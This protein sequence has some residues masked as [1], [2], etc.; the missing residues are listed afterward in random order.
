[1][2]SQQKFDPPRPPNDQEREPV[3]APVR[4]L[5]DLD[6]GAHHDEVGAFVSYIIY[7]DDGAIVYVDRND[8]LNYQIS[9]RDY[10]QWPADMSRIEAAAASLDAQPLDHLGNAQKKQ[11]LTLCGQGMAVILAK[12][13]LRDAI[14]ILKQAQAYFEARTSEVFRQRYLFFILLAVL[15][16]CGCSFA[17][18]QYHDQL[19]E[20]Y[21][22]NAGIIVASAFLASLGVLVSV[23]LRLEAIR[24]SSV[25]PIR[26]HLLESS[27][28]VL[29][30]VIAGFVTALAIK[31]GVILEGVIADTSLDLTLV[32]A[33]IVSGLSERALPNLAKRLQEVGVD[34]ISDTQ[35]EVSDNDNQQVDRTENSVPEGDQGRG[36]RSQPLRD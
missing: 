30:G 15:V 35:Q 25:A 6:E 20:T 17:A 10:G 33:S 4:N 23:A 16:A 32:I 31:A 13:S 8:N 29:V 1:M 7:Q 36:M 22:E 11:F 21:G 24:V 27:V 5:K 3:Q 26:L 34:V 14:H 2:D 28:R 9:I 18:W 12:G 19:D